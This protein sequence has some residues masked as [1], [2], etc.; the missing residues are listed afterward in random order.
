MS[1]S[2]RL[3]SDIWGTQREILRKRPKNNNKVG[4]KLSEAILSILKDCWEKTYLFLM[5]PSKTDGRVPSQQ[6]AP[7]TPVQPDLL[8]GGGRKLGGAWGRSSLG[9]RFLTNKTYQLFYLN[10]ELPF[11]QQHF[12]SKDI[13]F[14]SHLPA[15]KHFPEEQIIRGTDPFAAPVTWQQQLSFNSG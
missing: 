5:S 6:G 14:L 9:E 2:V 15:S 7:T 13:S 4:I 10:P 11:S 3:K 1:E 8:G 12:P